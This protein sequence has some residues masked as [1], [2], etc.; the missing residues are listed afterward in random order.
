MKTLFVKFQKNKYIKILQILEEQKRDQY[1]ILSDLYRKR[2][3]LQPLSW[4]QRPSQA[5]DTPF[6]PPIRR[7]S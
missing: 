5:P 3:A 2:K 1:Q 6:S 7:A 4:A